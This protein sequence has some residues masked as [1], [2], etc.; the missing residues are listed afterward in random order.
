M[1]VPVV[2]VLFCQQT[3]PSWV[4]LHFAINQLLKI[5]LFK[6]KMQFGNDQG[7]TIGEKYSG[8]VLTRLVLESY[9]KVQARLL[10]HLINH[11]ILNL[12]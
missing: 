5:R 8:H 4:H 7:Q 10:F 12:P 6:I 1:L 2:V 9:L 11:M 3:K